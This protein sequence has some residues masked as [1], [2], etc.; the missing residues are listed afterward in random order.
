MSNKETEKGSSNKKTN[1]LILVAIILLAGL[2]IF[3]GDIDEFKDLFKEET[4]P[5]TP[6][7]IELYRFDDVFILRLNN[8]KLNL[9]VWLKNIGETKASNI[10]CFIRSRDQNGTILFE[11]KIDL[12]FFILD[13]DE[14]CSGTCSM[15][16]TG[17]E[18]TITHTVEVRWDEGMNSYL[19]ETVLR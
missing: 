11:D 4:T 14:T 6:A 2:I 10:S 12:T 18:T 19:E 7:D 9:E 17:N 1:A 15:S 3:E 5:A 8:S 16:I 13:A